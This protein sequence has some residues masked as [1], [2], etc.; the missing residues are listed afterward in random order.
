MALAGM[1]AVLIPLASGAQGRY[2]A[3]CFRLGVGIQAV[4]AG[5]CGATIPGN[6]TAFFWNPALAERA[7]PSAY[8]EEAGVFGSLNSSLARL[9]TA[10][11][12]LPLGRAGI[13]QVGYVHF[14]VEDIPRYPSL[15]ESS[16]VERLADPTLRGGVE[17]DGWF[18]DGE[19]ALYWCYAHVFR[20]PL[21]LSWMAEEL[22]LELP[23]GV[24]AK[25]LSHR[26]DAWRARGAGVDIGA[27]LRLDLRQLW[28]GTWSGEFL[29]AWRVADVLGTRLRWN[30]GSVEQIR[31]AKS[32]GMAYAVSPVRSVRFLFVAEKDQDTASWPKFG[33]GLMTDRFELLAGRGPEGLNFGLLLGL[34]R[35]RIGYARQTTGLGPV[36]R[37]G[38]EFLW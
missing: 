28:Q 6:G 24:S 13:V 21:R 27:A 34:G 9:R 33:T 1:A 17:P 3:E 22:L 14:A 11:V 16:F 7:H 23:L 2:A 19:S 8:F 31:P 25:L 30:S 20:L 35:L 12:G 5:S 37:I 29:L 4:A 15:G 32:F 18:E 10:A 26:L 36:E 38:A